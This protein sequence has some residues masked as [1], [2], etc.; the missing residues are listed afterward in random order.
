VIEVAQRYGLSSLT[1]ASPPAEWE[2]TSVSAT[3]IARYY[4]L[5]VRQTPQ[6]D[7]DYVLGLLRRISPAA[8]D[9]FNQVFGLATAF[10]GE[11]VGIKQGW[12]CCPDGN[13]YLHSTGLVGSDNRYSVAILTLEP[14]GSLGLYRTDVLDG[15]AMLIFQSGISVD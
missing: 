14:N 13:S 11:T 1:P 8:G 6:V 3:D 15:I 4:D 10:A 7:R 2:L 9:G 5:F 12:M